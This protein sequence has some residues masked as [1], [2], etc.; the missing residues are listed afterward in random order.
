VTEP[1]LKEVAGRKNPQQVRWGSLQFAAITIMMRDAFLLILR[2]HGVFGNHRLAKG[3]SWKD[4]ADSGS[5]RLRA[6]DFSLMGP[7]SHLDSVAGYEDPY[8]FR[9]P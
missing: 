1:Q 5:D 6:T 7:L 4:P 9:F 8:Q 3:F 2:L